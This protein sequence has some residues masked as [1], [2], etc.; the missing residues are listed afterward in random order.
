MLR[1][2]GTLQGHWQ[3]HLGAASLQHGDV[4][5]DPSAQHRLPGAGFCQQNLDPEPFLVSSWPGAVIAV[6]VVVTPPYKCAGYSSAHPCCPCLRALGT[7]TQAAAPAPASHDPVK[8][9]F[10]PSRTPS[11]G[12]KDI[13]TAW[14]RKGRRQNALLSSSIVVNE[15]HHV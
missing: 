1:C 4:G 3:R 12:R 8:S 15:R 10:S 5:R 6:S 11:E 7:Q 13:L 9:L 14:I 2:W